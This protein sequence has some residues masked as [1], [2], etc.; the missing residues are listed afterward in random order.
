MRKTFAWPPRRG[1]IAP[2]RRHAL[3]TSTTKA[4]VL[5]GLCGGLSR[6]TPESLTP[7][8]LSA[9]DGESRCDSPAAAFRIAGVVGGEGG[10][11]AQAYAA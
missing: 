7:S 5:E 3:E 8:C 9:A 6:S 4:V 2:L 11:R 1:K 10:I